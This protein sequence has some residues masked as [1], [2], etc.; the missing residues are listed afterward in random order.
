MLS[1]KMTNRKRRDEI[2]RF[3]E[4]SWVHSADANLGGQK[5]GSYPEEKRNSSFRVLLFSVQHS[6]AEHM[7]RG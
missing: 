2:L 7:R 1:Q 5:T 6:G 3:L 4:G